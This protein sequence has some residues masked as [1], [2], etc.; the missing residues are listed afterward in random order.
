MAAWLPLLKAALPYVTDIVAERLPVF[1]K[2]KEQEKSAAELQALHSEQIAELQQAAQHGA[3]QT[4]AL[5]EQLK[6]AL[7]A[8]EAGASEQ[9][10]LVA[11]LKRTVEAQQAQLE[12]LQNEREKL[13]GGL[14][15]VR[16][17]CAI[18]FGTAILAITVT[19]AVKVFS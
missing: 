18:A 1:T 10:Q 7:S 9:V 11:E 12:A 8:I 13:K 4:K 15:S 14:N 6:T 3:E 5:A 19:A 17:L 2:R 16:V